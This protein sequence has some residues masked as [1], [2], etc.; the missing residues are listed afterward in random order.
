MSC[1]L[2]L[3]CTSIVHFDKKVIVEVKT[4]QELCFVLTVAV[5]YSQGKCLQA[6]VVIIFYFQFFRNLTNLLHSAANAMNM[7]PWRR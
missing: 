3:H 2:C 7:N 4:W 1:S 5:S 6:K